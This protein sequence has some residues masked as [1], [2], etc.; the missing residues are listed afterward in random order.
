LPAA[1]A[2]GSQSLPLTEEELAE[3]RAWRP[4]KADRAASNQVGPRPSRAAPSLIATHCA[5]C[6]GGATPKAGLSLD[7]SLTPQVRLRAIR[8]VL[9][10]DM[11]PGRPLAAAELTALLRELAT[12]APAA[13]MSRSSHQK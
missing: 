1:A 9:Q 6:H 8:A 13:S 4:A 10:G 7:G 3:F 11:P 5:T 12:D 2:N